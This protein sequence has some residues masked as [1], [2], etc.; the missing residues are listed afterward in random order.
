MPVFNSLQG[1][2][3]GI[4]EGLICEAHRHNIRVVD[5]DVVNGGFNV[6]FVTQ[7]HQFA[8]ESAVDIWVEEVAHFMQT[9]GIDGV[10]LVRGEHFSRSGGEV[11]PCLYSL[12]V[13]PAR[14]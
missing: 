9:V 14:L 10:N 12:R 4:N 6:E 8:N 5:E 11:A 1:L 7:P 3:S 13:Y 2:G